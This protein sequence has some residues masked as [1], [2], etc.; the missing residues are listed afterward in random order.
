MGHELL[1]NAL[2]MLAWL[3]LGRLGWWA[4]RHGRP[5][6]LQATPTPATPIKTR[7]VA[8]AFVPPL[9]HRC[10]GNPGHTIP[11][12]MAAGRMSRAACLWLHL[13][14]PT[15]WGQPSSGGPAHR[16]WPPG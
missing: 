5:A 4:W 6:A 14:R 16:R 10:A 12:T 7:A 3:W 2:L 8:S 1:F 15:A 9:S 11:S 13:S